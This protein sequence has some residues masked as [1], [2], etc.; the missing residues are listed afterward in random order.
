[1]AIDKICAG[2]LSPIYA[3]QG[4]VL[5]DVYANRCIPCEQLAALLVRLAQDPA[6]PIPIYQMNVSETGHDV[7]AQ[8]LG[9]QL[10]PSLLLLHAGQ[11]Q[12]QLN[13]F[14]AFASSELPQFDDDYIAQHDMMDL[15]YVQIIAFIKRFVS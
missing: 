15:S 10:T 6:Y 13:V 7:I 9:V 11:V 12:A 3:Q 2:D 14:G 1:M 5:L 4:F 8:Q